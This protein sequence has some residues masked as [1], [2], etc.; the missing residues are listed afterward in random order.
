MYSY[1]YVV[2]APYPYPYPFLIDAGC[3]SGDHMRCADRTTQNMTSPTA[4]FT[5]SSDTRTARN[6]LRMWTYLTHRL[7]SAEAVRARDLVAFASM[8]IAKRF[9]T[10]GPCPQD[11]RTVLPPPP[12]PRGQQACGPARHPRWTIM[13]CLNIASSLLG[14]RSTL[15]PPHA[16][17]SVAPNTLSGAGVDV[18]DISQLGGIVQRK[19]P[20]T[21]PLRAPTTDSPDYR[22]RR[23]HSSRT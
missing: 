2:A 19:E 8:L 3:G 18:T 14:R 22:L 17:N 7:D 13:M 20:P 16:L 4:P 23:S 15:N 1:V 21:L 11:L 10:D 9:S 6:V 12:G 5:G